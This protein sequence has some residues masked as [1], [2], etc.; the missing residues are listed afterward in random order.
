MTNTGMTA[1][2][3]SNAGALVCARKWVV[4]AL[5]VA[6]IAGVPLPAEAGDP[7]KMVYCMFGK[8]A[9]ATGQGG[10]GGSE[11][12]QAEAEYFGIIV[13]RKKGRIDWNATAQERLGRQNSC[14]TADRGKTKQINDKFGK[15]RG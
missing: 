7:C 6:G 14:P 3:R 13:Y 12:R 15:S 11:C 8:Y 9:K 5:L 2:P 4:A 10:D 1:A